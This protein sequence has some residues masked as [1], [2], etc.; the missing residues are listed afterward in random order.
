[1]EN[2]EMNH[3]QTDAGSTEPASAEAR[4]LSESE[5]SAAG[6]IEVEVEKQSTSREKQAQTQIDEL[7]AQLEQ[8]QQE[9][10]ETREKML[11]VAADVDNQRKRLQKEKEDF[12]RYGHEG[13][14]RE[15]LAPMDNLERTLTHLPQDASDPQ[16][17]SLRQGL[18]LVIKQLHDKLAK[19]H[20][21][22]FDSLGQAFDPNLHE[23][24]NSVESKEAA[25]GTVVSEFQRGYRLH[26]R[27]LRPALVTVARE[28]K[29]VEEPAAEHK[30]V[31]AESERPESQ[32]G[33]DGSSQ[34]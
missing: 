20:L 13:L 26:D 31:D 32:P 11:R 14:F 24:L 6:G 23:A 3:E 25:P 33:S 4:P 16:I 5:A 8:A 28:P 9:Q 22:P 34:G 10:R 1:M 7:Q 18:T 12:L 27:L 2:E 30:A 17:Q 21:M 19:F 15:L 29:P